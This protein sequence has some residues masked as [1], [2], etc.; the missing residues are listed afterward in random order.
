VAVALGLAGL[1]ASSLGLAGWVLRDR[2]WIPAY[3]RD[4]HVTAHVRRWV[5]VNIGAA[6]CVAFGLIG[7]IF[8]WRRRS[9]LD[10]LEKITRLLAPLSLAA[11]AVFLFD[12]RLWPDRD[13]VFLTF[14][15]G[16]GFGLRAA[17]RTSSA[18]NISSPRVNDLL[19]RARGRIRLLAKDV[20]LPL[21]SVLAGAVLYAAH[22]SVITIAHHRNFGSSAFDLGGWDNLMWNIV[23]GRRGGPM[24]ASTPFV[25][26]AA[27]HM[28]R[29]A[30]FFAYLIAP[31]YALSPHPETL[32][33]LQATMLGGAALPLFLYARRHLPA[34]TAALV[35][36]LYLI[37][38][39]LHGAN[40]YDFQF[41]PLFIP[42]LWLLLW[43]IDSGRARWAVAAAILALSVREDVGFCVGVLGLW[44]LLTGAAAREGTLLTVV[45]LAYFLVLKLGV[46]PRF[47]DG[48]ETFVNQYAG[49]LPPGEHTF[50]SILETITANPP[51]TANVVLERDK[52]VYVLKLLGPVLLA[53]L[54]IPFGFVM[55]LPGLV[56]TLLS[57]GYQ[58]LY[59][60]SFQ[61][62][63]YWTPFVFIGL[64]VQLE[65]VGRAQH[66]AD[67]EGALRRR[68]LAAGVAAASLACSYLYGA[69]IPHPNL[70]CG[71]EPPRFQ[72]TP[73]DVRRRAEL[74][75]LSPQIP[76]DAKVAAA[77][78]L[79]PHVSGRRDAYTLR[80]GVHDA[81]YILLTIPMR[82]D[83][84]DAA[85]PLLRDGTFGV[86]EDL[87]DMALA[88]RG[89]PTMR[90]D[91][92]V[93]R[94]A[95]P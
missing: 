33:T 26:P 1:E 65:R 45:G 70:R 82:G 46:M 52:L 16:W 14:V 75:E 71:H 62:T 18:A 66:P 17:L 47:A 51:F 83:E 38:P 20:D 67:V 21:L 24:L 87:G 29:H 7:A 13:M 32:L 90:N 44:L 2:T 81:D 15:L 50:G 19:A 54:A 60:I 56:F 25:G 48:S 53:P 30:T 28:A 9:G 5:F 64:V 6:L 61:Y 40:L 8:L 93:A 12:H 84:R 86:L 68:T 27:S 10:V 41:L 37:Y 42:F 76:E 72:S 89:E 77:E 57:T 63:A 31:I 49:L 80:F 59:M 22:F 73:E 94:A 91:A 43:A 3:A 58:P 39:P 92:L 85:L 95:Q 88:R 35:A 69:I 36:L 55:L 74:A 79:L 4:N 34:W 11:L 78:H 23:H